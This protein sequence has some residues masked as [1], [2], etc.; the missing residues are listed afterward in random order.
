MLKAVHDAEASNENLKRSA[1]RSLLIL[2]AK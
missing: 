1:S 2:P